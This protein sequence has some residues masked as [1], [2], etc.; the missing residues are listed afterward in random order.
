VGDTHSLSDGPLGSWCNGSSSIAFALPLLEEGVLGYQFE[1]N[2][3]L[4][5]GGKLYSQD[6]VERQGRG[7]VLS[8]LMHIFIVIVVPAQWSMKELEIGEFNAQEGITLV[9][10]IKVLS[11]VVGHIVIRRS[12]IAEIFLCLAVKEFFPPTVRRFDE[13]CKLFD[14]LL[15]GAPFP[16]QHSEH[17]GNV[18]VPPHCWKGDSRDAK[19][20]SSSPTLFR[21]LGVTCE[22]RVLRTT[23]FAIGDSSS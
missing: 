20:F 6:R 8:G 1:L 16:D 14:R 11:L 3:W 7:R 9:V 21:F 10:F 13:T 5:H 2:R 18:S 17:Y 23:F 22:P 12:T 15:P 4:T 19:D